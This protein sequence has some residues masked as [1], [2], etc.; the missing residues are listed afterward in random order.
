MSRGAWL[1]VAVTG[2]TAAVGLGVWTWYLAGRSLD[3]MDQTASVMSSFVALAS[4]VVGIIG[5][6]LAVRSPGSGGGGT[7]RR[8]FQARDASGARVT[9]GDNSS[10]TDKDG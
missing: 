1:G 5:L 3:V 8:S 6:I 7:G 10:I 4:L 9:F 2:M